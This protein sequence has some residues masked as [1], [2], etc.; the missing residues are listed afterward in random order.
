MEP[1]LRLFHYVFAQTQLFQFVDAQS[2]YAIMYH[3]KL[4]FDLII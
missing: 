2:F 4:L 3:Q 1:D